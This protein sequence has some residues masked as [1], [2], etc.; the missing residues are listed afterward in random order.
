MT[1]FSNVIEGEEHETQFKG[2]NKHTI[3]FNY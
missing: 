1:W 3:V 2:E